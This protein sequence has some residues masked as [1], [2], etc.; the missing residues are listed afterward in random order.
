MIKKMRK[1]TLKLV[2]L[3]VLSRRLMP[4]HPKRKYIEGD[5]AK[6]EAGYKGEKSLDYFLELITDKEILVFHDLRLPIIQTKDYFQID[7]LIVTPYFIAVVE[8]KNIN[9]NIH[10]DHL[11]DQI[12][13]TLNG[14]Q[15]AFQDPV[16]QAGRQ[17]AHL[18]MLLQHKPF[19]QIPIEHLACFTN[20]ISVITFSNKYPEKA[21]LKVIRPRISRK[22]WNISR[23]CILFL[24]S[25]KVTSKK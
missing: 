7:T 23:I 10:F 13:R 17:S 16:N 4:N 3:E 24:S 12:I 8:V 20:S 14:E 2:K 22:N 25:Q 1:R 6:L 11:A 9:G 19:Q 21:K 15:E 5:L 18:M